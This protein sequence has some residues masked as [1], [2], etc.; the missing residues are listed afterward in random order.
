MEVGCDAW[1][2]GT[3]SADLDMVSHY[4]ILEHSSP[5]L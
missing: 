2:L 3:L 5:P 4:H 1:E